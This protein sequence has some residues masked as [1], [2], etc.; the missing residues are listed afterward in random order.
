M[1]TVAMASGTLSCASAVLTKM[2]TIAISTSG[3]SG[4]AISM[5]VVAASTRS[6]RNWPSTS[7]TST[8]AS[9]PSTRGRKRMMA[10]SELPRLSSPST[11]TAAT[12]TTTT[13]VQRMAVPISRDSGAAMPKRARAV[14]TPWRFATSSMPVA[15]R[16]RVIARPTSHASTSPTIRS[17]TAPAKRG[18]YSPSVVAALSTSVDASGAVTTPAPA[19]DDALSS[20]VRLRG[21][22]RT[23][24][25][26]ASRA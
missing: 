9:A 23:R 18:R 22:R 4:A 21:S 24:A 7:P 6:R 5:R 2:A 13:S 20:A 19:A 17:S 25:G 16:P 15:C 10:L 14:S 12:I 1:I 11:D 26:C 8:S 3:P